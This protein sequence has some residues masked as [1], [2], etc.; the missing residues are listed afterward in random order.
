MA[1]GARPARPPP[2]LPAAARAL[3]RLF[4]LAAPLVVAQTRSTKAAAPA[5]G[6]APPLLVLQRPTSSFT[7]AAACRKRDRRCRRRQS[8]RS[9]PAARRHRRTMAAMTTERREHRLGSGALTALRPN[10][11]AHTRVARG[12]WANTHG[13]AEGQGRPPFACRRRRRP[14][15]GA[16]LPPAAAGPTLALS[17]M[18]CSLRG[19]DV[20]IPAPGRRALLPRA[21]RQQ[22][23]RRWRAGRCRCARVPA[24]AG[25][26][27]RR[28]QHGW[29]SP[30]R[31]DRAAPHFQPR[32]APAVVRHTAR[33]HLTRRQIAQ[34][35]TTQTHMHPPVFANERARKQQRH[36][37][38]TWAAPLPAR[39]GAAPPAALRRATS[40]AHH[41]THTRP[42]YSRGSPHTTS[43]STPCAAA[44][45]ATTNAEA[46]IAAPVAHAGAQAMRSS[47][48]AGALQRAPAAL[49]GGTAVPGRASCGL[50]QQQRNPHNGPVQQP[51][52]STLRA[53]CTVTRLFQR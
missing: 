3:R 51:S 44:A 38:R 28:D 26:W 33:A 37:S 32:A 20:V 35:H 9:M 17:C 50:T 15:A 36:H 2:A 5:A 43:P 34:H 14:D 46:A 47:Q 52:P 11:P 12:R 19:A 4:D 23:R 48:S 7:R 1:A 53:L 29:A 6:A 31:A 45:A 30:T 21:R 25:R 18:T 39:G 24:A 16:R 22:E 49:R 40:R 13:G 41:T 10:A 8:W 27:T 42:M